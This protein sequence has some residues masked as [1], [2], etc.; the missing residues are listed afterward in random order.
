MS[1]HQTSLYFRLFEAFYPN[2]RPDQ[3]GEKTVKSY[4]VAIFEF[5]EFCCTHVFANGLI[6]GE[7]AFAVCSGLAECQRVLHRENLD[8]NSHLGRALCARLGELLY[9]PRPRRHL[10]SLQLY[11]RQQFVG[12]SVRCSLFL[13]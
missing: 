8:N 11:V 6:I 1:C 3:R 13:L 7:N 9:R 4:Q 5:H 2:V 10:D 12:F